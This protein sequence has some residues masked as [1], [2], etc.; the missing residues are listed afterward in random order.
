MCTLLQGV[1]N[2]V[3]HM[4]NVMNKV[5]KNYIPEN[6]MPFLDDIP[7]KGCLVELKDES[8]NEDGC[9]KFVVDHIAD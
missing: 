3:A 7:I 6:T 8:R 4:V 5:L 2:S 9:Q 1:T